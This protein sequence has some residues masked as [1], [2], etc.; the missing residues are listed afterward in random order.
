MVGE[1]LRNLGYDEE[2]GYINA[3]NPYWGNHELV[4]VGYDSQHFILGNSWGAAWGTD[5]FFKAVQGVL[6]TDVIDLW[7]L[8]SFSGVD[9]V[10]VDFTTR[11]NQVSTLYRTVLLREPD[12][13]GL[14]YWSNTTYTMKYIKKQFILSD[15]YTKS[16][17]VGDRTMVVK[18]LYHDILQRPADLAGLD[19][20]VNSGQSFS[21][22]RDAFFASPE[23]ST[24]Q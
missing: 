24:I 13:A 2:Y 15:E 4:V 19:Y 3:T 14:N 6:A 22:I 10:G 18:T 17:L 23:Y 21:A 16:K 12:Q 5:G 9:R 20:W 11:T 7:V 8:V 1:K